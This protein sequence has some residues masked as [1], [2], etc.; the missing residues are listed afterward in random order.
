[1]L[2]A[3]REHKGKWVFSVVALDFLFQWQQPNLLAH[4]ETVILHSKL[5]MKSHALR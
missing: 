5:K 2:L 1:L 4:Y 3:K